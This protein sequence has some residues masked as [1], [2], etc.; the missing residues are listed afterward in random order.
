MVLSRTCVL[1]LFDGGESDGHLGR[2]TRKLDPQ[3]TQIDNAEGAATPSG[4]STSR[5]VD[6]AQIVKPLPHLNEGPQLRTRN[7]LWL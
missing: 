5:S 4:I 6:P 3:P 7:T 1:K 2:S